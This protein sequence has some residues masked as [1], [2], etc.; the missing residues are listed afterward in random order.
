MRAVTSLLLSA[1]ALGSSFGL[2]WNS[3]NVPAGLAPL[4]SSQEGALPYNVYE[5]DK[6]K[7]AELRT[8]REKL[9]EKMPAGSVAV[10][11]TNPERQRSNDTDFRFRPNSDF[12]YLTGCEEPNTALLLAKDG[13]VIDG[14]NVYEVLFV[15]ERNPRSEV[16]TGIK[17]GPARAKV[18][19]G[20]DAV[21]PT[22]RFSEVLKA[23]APTQIG[24]GDPVVGASGVLEQMRSA[25]AAFSEGKTVWR[26]LIREI[27]ALRTTKSEHELR[28]LKRAVDSTVAAH[29]EA[30]KSCEPGMREFEI[31][32]L[33]EYIFARNGC[34]AVA[35]GSIVGSGMNSCILHYVDNRKRIQNGDILCMD[36]GGEYHGYA[37]DVTRS[38]PANGK[39]TPAQRAIYQLVLE[40][41][42]AGI[43]ACQ[44]GAP[45]RAYDAACREVVSK[46]LVKLGIIQEPA[47]ARRYFM[48]GSGH[49]LGLD[50]H[51][52][53]VITTLAPNQVLTVE[54]GIYIAPGSP[55]DPKWWSIGIRIEDDILITEKGPVNL[56]AGV[57]RDIA[58]IEK[59][60]AQKGLGNNPAG[61]LKDA[62]ARFSRGDDLHNCLA[63]NHGH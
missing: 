33:V 51:D 11:F 46:G 4:L 14:Q 42:D 32:A 37:A 49:Y 61:K 7:P 56:S 57:P 36:V 24:N 17:M 6:I 54:P 47:E 55:C 20:V 27:G 38:Y 21:L 10:L 41:Q 16:W 44:N 19:L 31:Q 63:E 29:S 53:Q 28:L 26:G 40:A 30:I 9:L 8:R 23:V 5:E 13:I 3:S 22:S 1:L 59:L 45:F 48:H 2:T 25:Y 35:Y 34:E 18:E 58:S 60:M 12:W 50:V 15:P 52:P 43:K 39:F 62:L